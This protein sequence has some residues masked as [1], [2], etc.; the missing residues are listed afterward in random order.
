[1]QTDHG[2]QHRGHVIDVIGEHGSQGDTQDTDADTDNRGD[3]WHA[4]G[5]E[6]TEGDDQDDGCDQ[7]TDD[8]GGHVDGGRR[9]TEDV[10][11]VHNGEI[12]LVVLVEDVGDRLTLL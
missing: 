7:Q 1:G 4:S 5:D 8:L 12:A 6:G 2:G 10:A 11:V 3:Q 9:S